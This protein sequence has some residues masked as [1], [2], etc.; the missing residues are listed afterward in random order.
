MRWLAPTWA[1][2]R[3]ACQ[4]GVALPVGEKIL[5]NVSGSFGGV[6]DVYKRAAYAA[7]KGAALDKWAAGVDAIV[8][9]SEDR[10]NG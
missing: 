5:N 2:A 3:C 6:A 4:C 8:E 7:E 9:A 10:A 1:C